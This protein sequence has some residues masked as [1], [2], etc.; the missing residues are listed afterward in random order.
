MQPE[1][2]LWQS[3]IPSD[4]RGSVSKPE[5]VYLLRETM[6]CQLIWETG[7]WVV[8]CDTVALSLTLTLHKPTPVALP[9]ELFLHLLQNL[10]FR[11][12]HMAYLLLAESIS[13]GF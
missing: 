13:Y 3:I 6:G 11:E 12:C 9:V 5:I 1:R 8:R 7:S 2:Y 4:Q 10:P